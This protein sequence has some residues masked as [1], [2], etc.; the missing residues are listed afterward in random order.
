TGYGDSMIDYNWSQ[1][2]VGIGVALNDLLDQP[3]PG[4]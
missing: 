3:L 4:F 2:A 1:N